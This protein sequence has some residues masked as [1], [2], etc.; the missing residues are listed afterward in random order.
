ML[1]KLWGENVA[2][3]KTSPFEF[4]GGLISNAYEFMGAHCKNGITVFRVWAPAAQSVSVVGD[5]N[6]WD[7]FA[8]PMAKKDGGIWE[9]EIAGLSRYTNYK[10]AVTNGKT[11]L[12]SDPFAFHCE[13]PPGTASKLYDISDLNGTIKNGRSKTPAAVITAQSIF[14]RCIWAHGAATPTAV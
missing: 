7:A 14:M 10:Y 12:K 9:T 6:G 4:C 13:T 11:V 2:T 8:N 3:S 5:F 1:I